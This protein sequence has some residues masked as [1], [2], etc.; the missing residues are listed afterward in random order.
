MAPSYNELAAFFD[1]QQQQQ[2][3]QQIQPIIDPTRESSRHTR[4]S[5]SIE[6]AAWRKEEQRKKRKAMLGTAS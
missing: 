2:Q 4:L 1:Q 3:Q 5:T 6:Q